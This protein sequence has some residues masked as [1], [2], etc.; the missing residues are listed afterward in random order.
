MICQE[1]E[2]LRRLELYVTFRFSMLF[3]LSPVEMADL[4]HE[5]FEYTTEALSTPHPQTPPYPWCPRL[6]SVA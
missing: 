1:C 4:Y 5:V 6:D 2:I 3:P